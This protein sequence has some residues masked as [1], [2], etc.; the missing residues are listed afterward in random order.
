[1]CSGCLV[2]T[3]WKEVYC[4]SGI[5]CQVRRMTGADVKPSIEHF[6]SYLDDMAK[7]KNLPFYVQNYIKTVEA[8]VEVL[9]HDGVP[10]NSCGEVP[11]CHANGTMLT[12]YCH[13]VFFNDIEDLNRENRER[14]G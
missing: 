13:M 4:A 5:P 3:E 11:A 6:E 12:Y 9:K 10:I 8:V 1:M 7:R 2:M 14:Y